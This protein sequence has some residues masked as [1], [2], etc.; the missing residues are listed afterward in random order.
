MRYPITEAA[1]N[2]VGKAYVR[3]LRANIK[4]KQFPYGHPQSG[5]GNKI[6][7]GDLYNSIGYTIVEYEGQPAIQITY[8]DYFENVNQGR[9]VGAKRVPL[10]SLISWINI[11]GIKPPPT[12][13][14]GRPNIKK[15]AWAIQTN[16]FK[17]GV[18]PAE[19]YDKALDG[20]EQW[21]DPNTPKSRIPQELLPELNN[22]FNAI[23]EDMNN[24]VENI[25]VETL[26]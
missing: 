2:Q 15:L 6:A 18:R 13:K 1:L 5:V 16:I 19:L 23:Q 9:R 26:Y 22:L 17:Y 21:L 24:L 7:F 20:V 4:K 14:R 10:K 12:G 3:I 25:I 11:K 8:A